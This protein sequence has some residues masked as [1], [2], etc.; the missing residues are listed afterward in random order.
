MCR[1]IK[2]ICLID[3]KKFNRKVWGMRM[4]IW[5]NHWNLLSAIKSTSN[6]NYQKTILHLMNYT[7]ASTFVSWNVL[8]WSTRQSTLGSPDWIHFTVHVSAQIMQFLEWGEWE[9]QN[10]VLLFWI[11]FTFIE[12]GINRVETFF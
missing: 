12:G 4:V 10:G 11:L 8:G 6:L 1:H 7:L 5:N 2:L 3:K 9:I